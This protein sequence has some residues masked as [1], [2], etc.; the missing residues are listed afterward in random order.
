MP[1]A[2]LQTAGLLLGWVRD[3]QPKFH[4]DRDNLLRSVRSLFFAGHRERTDALFQTRRLVIGLQSS[5]QYVICLYKCIVGMVASG[6]AVLAADR[7]G[8]QDV[9]GRLVTTFFS[10]ALRV[11]LHF[12]YR[13]VAET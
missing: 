2:A 1:C 5:K 12:T 4:E 10:L 13:L 11:A 7:Q 6:A 8:E 3:R 9:V